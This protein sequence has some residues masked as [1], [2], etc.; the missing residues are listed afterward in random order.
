MLPPRTHPDFSTVLRQE[1]ERQGL[2]Q[3]ELAR[4]ALLANPLPGRYERGV[5]PGHR[6]WERLN[7]ALFPGSRQT[8]RAVP[9]LLRYSHVQL[10]EELERRGAKV[11]LEWPPSEQRDEDSAD[12]SVHDAV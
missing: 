6:S 12:S 3:S 11:A 1:R 4:R 2:S 10:V 8:S 9:N 5:V 7:A